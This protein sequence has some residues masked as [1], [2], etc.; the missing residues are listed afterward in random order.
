MLT[1]IRPYTI[2]IFNHLLDFLLIYITF[3][4]FIVLLHPFTNTILAIKLLLFHLLLLLWMLLLFF[5]SF[6][7]F[8]RICVFI[9]FLRFLFDII[10]IMILLLDLRLVLCIIIITHSSQLLLL[11]L[12]PSIFINRSW[13]LKFRC[14]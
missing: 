1:F 4:L 14:L 11:F 10:M 5:V 3:R 2:W 8:C 7:N 12:F 9:L 13:N 6:S